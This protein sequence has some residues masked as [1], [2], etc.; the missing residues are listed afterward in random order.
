MAEK[1]ELQIV[2]DNAD[3]IQKTKQVEDATKSMQRSVQEGDKRQKGLIEDQIA[4]LK[5]L[6]KARVKANN[7]KD[8]IKINQRIAEGTKNLKEFQQLGVKTDETISKQ[9]KSTNALWSSV[10]KLAAAY[11]TVNA[12]IKIFKSI[13]DSTQ[14]SGDFLRRTVGSLTLSLGELWRSIATGNLQDLGKRMQEAGKAGSEYAD[15]L[16]YIGDR[17]REL[18]I[19]EGERK[20]QLAELAKIYRNTALSHA[21]QAAAAEKY[22]ALTEEGLREGL[23]LAELKLQAELKLASQQTAAAGEAGRL[24][25]EEIQNNLRRA[26]FL[27]QNMAAVNQYRQALS[28]LAAEE[29]KRAEASISPE[30]IPLPGVTG[31]DP[32][33]IALYKQQIAD[34][35]DEIKNLSEEMKGWNLVTDEQRARIVEAINE[36]NKKREEQVSST[37]RANVKIEMANKDAVESDKKAEDERLN[38]LEKFVEATARLRDEYEQAQIEQLTGVDR[39]RAEQEFELRQVQLLEDHLKTLGDL[40]ED[41]YKYLDGLRAAANKRAEV[42]ELEYE[43]NIYNEMVEHGDKVRELE[44]QIQE[45]ALE[46]IEDNEK[47]KAE[48]KIKFYEEDI[49]RLS[50]S[51]DPLAQLEIKRLQQLIAILRGEIAKASTD[52]GFSIWDIIDPKGELSED[53]RQEII[54]N[55]K[56]VV[57]NITA[58]FDEMYSKRLED[59]QRTRELLDDQ[60]QMTQD[61]L[62]AEIELMTAG[63]A[64]NVDAKRK[65]LEELKKEREKALKEE[66]RALKAKQQM[67]SAYQAASIISAIA[68]IFK[69]ASAFGPLGWIAAIAASA[70][71]V[72]AFISA[73][74]KAAAATKLAEGGAGTE[75][76][77]IKGR[78]HREG[79]ERFLDHVEVERG[80]MWGVLS[81]RAT[82]KYGKQFG[83]IV[84]SFNRDQI[85]VAQMSD[86][87]NNIL[88]DVNQ[89]N[90]RLDRVQ[91][92][93]KK[94]NQHFGSDVQVRETAT[95][96]IEKRGNK[97]R[98]IRKNV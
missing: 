51:T 7:E 41:H 59:A 66:E 97:T 89:T 31:P 26:E 13:M 76:G 72:G 38:N 65:E 48:L 32:K 57:D 95:A 18:M 16:D 54:D 49:Q 78:S 75:T 29:A 47:A 19:R 2:A 74:T 56:L 39:I 37:I 90:E 93:L 10:K 15:A 25:E 44:R 84:T 43:S 87:H 64:N 12:A 81:K 67:E 80:E 82:A 96:R 35:S 27:Q 1:I 53:K 91:N 73:K 86:V 9:A 62:N 4:A 8:L 21:E 36:I 85:P 5:E 68:N 23:E 94:L 50:Q 33:L 46:L 24:T 61:A 60:I 22:I 28:N 40:T 92:E 17:G 79:G 20:I 45:D 52:G 69:G 88:V 77:I 34:T 70:A 58:M 6:E 30:G 63:Y 98:I 83:Q 3:Y 71:M 42:A 14:A 11:L 55:V